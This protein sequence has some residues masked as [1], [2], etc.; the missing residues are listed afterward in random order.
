[1]PSEDTIVALSTPPGRSGIGVIRLSGKDSL[2]LL[3]LLV[4]DES[5]NP[6]PRRAYL[7]K[8][9]DF[10]TQSVLDIALVTFFCAP[11]SF[12]GED[13]IELSCHGSPVLLSAVIRQTLSLGARSASPGEFTLRALA[14]GRLNLSEAEAIRDLIDAQTF[15]AVKQ[16]A[17]QVHG[18]LSATLQ[19][20]KNSLIDVIVK[21]ESSIEF[22]E[23]DLPEVVF[24]DIR[25]AVARAKERL[26]ALSSSFKSGRLLKEGLKIAIVGSPNVGKSS[27][28][29]NL[30]KR[31]RAIV[32]DIP[33]TTR[34]SL[35]E[36]IDLD[37][38]PILLTDTAGVRESKDVIERI[39]IERTQRA[40]SDADLI[41]FLLDGTR[42]ISRDDEEVLSLIKDHKF[43][44]VCNKLDAPEFNSSFS[45]S[46][47]G[48]INISALTGYGLEDLRTRIK[49]EF[50]SAK[51]LDSVFLITNAR[52]HD[53]LERA[54]REL[55]KVLQTLD[56]NAPEEIILVGLH[57]S[58]NLLG[59][60][61]GE[62]TS[63]EVLTKIFST[64]CIGK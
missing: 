45:E 2:S 62:T 28:F 49:S 58:L 10:E 50:F 7:K 46:F 38:I 53:L 6:E 18:E 16:S 63:E 23:D 33:G 30:I 54:V 41:L 32:T 26:C 56:R 15:T 5:F 31:E 60:I 8:I 20:V 35:T 52:H 14:N 17:R 36:E 11:K 22:V 37:G 39:G 55:Q 48:S 4:Q 42:G 59:E 34:D 61:T 44:A 19:P 51:D 43:F 40:I 29:N 3:R 13:V 25:N 64:F 24:H 12:T 21:L 27:L 47:G 57:N 9:Y 1:M